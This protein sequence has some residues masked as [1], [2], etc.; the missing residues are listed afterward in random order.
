MNI[1]KLLFKTLQCKWHC[2]C[3]AVQ[4]F[5]TMQTF[6]YHSL[7]K[8]EIARVWLCSFPSHIYFYY[9][10]YL[11]SSSAMFSCVNTIIK[12]IKVLRIYTH[13]H[14]W[15]TKPNSKI[16]YEIYM[17]I[18][19][20]VMYIYICIHICTNI[21]VKAFTLTVWNVYGIDLTSLSF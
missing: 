19:Q 6:S 3:Q 21:E 7:K 18:N 14:N 15:S 10:S 2:S 11:A 4:H 8:W 12:Q 1:H 20:C 13:T 5:R 16:L 9:I 17:Y